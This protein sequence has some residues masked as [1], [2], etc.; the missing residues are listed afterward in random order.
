MTKN[1]LKGSAILLLAALIW[2]LAF[3]AQSDAAD[4]IPPFAFNALRS[5]IAAV[6]LGGLLALRC[7][8]NGQSFIPTNR[9]AAL[10]T[11]LGG[12]AC[13]IFLAISVNLQQA[14]LGSY[15]DGVAASARGGFITAIYVIIVPILS[16]IFGKRI[17]WSVWPA[18][19]V[20][21]SGT[22]LLCLAGG[23]G[24]LY[25][26]DALMIGCATCFSFQILCID[27]FGEAIGG[28]RLSFIQFSVCA[29]ISLAL[30][31]IFEP[32]GF[33]LE[34]IKNA[35]WAILYLGVMS[36][37]VAY[38]LQIIGQRYAEPAIASLTMSLESVF[39][40]LGGW[41]IAGDYLS[42]REICGCALVFLAIIIVQIPDLVSLKK[43]KLKE[44]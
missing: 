25:L 23:L 28:V 4:H 3:V 13:G 36:S 37:G 16:V 41:V 31:L 38:T 27:R 18:V 19:L 29:V 6:L 24:G 9:N 34:G 30:S 7:R 43:K 12:A 8:K 14:G 2:G 20:A 11:L 15:P 40:A 33:A 26:G 44:K 22:Y 1:N 10:L 42:P 17:P 5:I 39:A 21:L 35:F 32:G